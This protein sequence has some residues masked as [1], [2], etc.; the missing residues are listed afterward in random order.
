MIPLAESQCVQE[1]FF[2]FQTVFDALSNEIQD[3]LQNGI[4]FDGSIFTVLFSS[5]EILGYTT[6]LWA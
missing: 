3:I 4:E 6:W 5:W 1:S 2:E